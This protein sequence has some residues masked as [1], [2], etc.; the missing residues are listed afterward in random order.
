MDERLRRAKD[1]LEPPWD[2]LREA[3]VLGRVLEQ[4]RTLRPQRSRLVWLAAAAAMAVGVLLL[5]VKVRTGT[6]PPRA[7]SATTLPA[8]DPLLT[9]ADGSFAH[10]SPG[11]RVA[12]KEASPR[13]VRLLQSDGQVRYEVKPDASRPFEV[14]AHNVKV[15]VVGTV[16]TVTVDP[17]AVSVKVE[18]GVVRVEDGARQVELRAGES[19]RVAGEAAAPQAV[20]SNQPSALPSE[21]ALEPPPSVEALL[22]VAD[23]A[24]RSGDLPRAAQALERLVERYPSDPRAVSA[25]FSLGRVERAR[26][27]HVKAAQAFRACYQRAPGGTLAQDALAEQATSLAQAGQHEQARA[28]ARQYLEQY[29][30]GTHARRMQ[31]LL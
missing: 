1:V 17:A 28:A 20:P 2:E 11:A 31:G 5:A 21:R 3:R 26:G 12:Q 10:L 29:S 9:L 27:R 16:F 24:R 13:A 25:W 8:E 30:S 7:A 4:R 14:L 18:R 22:A 19:L 6:A 23:A 15:S